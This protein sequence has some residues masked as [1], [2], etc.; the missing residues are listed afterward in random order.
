MGNNASF[1]YLSALETL[2]E[3]DPEN[4]NLK[5]AKELETDSTALIKKY[6]NM[7][8]LIADTYPPLPKDLEDAMKDATE[9]QDTEAMKDV[10][11]KIVA[12]YNEDMRSRLYRIR[13]AMEKYQTLSAE[14]KRKIE[15]A[16]G[17]EAV[18]ID[19]FEKMLNQRDDRIA[20][21]VIIVMI[22]IFIIAG[23]ISSVAYNK[24][25]YR[26]YNNYRY[27]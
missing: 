20:I 21:I 25:R 27:W 19:E 10:A 24:R 18:T 23:I 13:I 1:I 16:I 9:S 17:A 12:Y 14:R 26:Y 22:V 15:E 11:S 8:K 3:L 5:K 2:Q 7:T 6:P 4:E